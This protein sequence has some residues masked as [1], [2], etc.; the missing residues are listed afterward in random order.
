MNILTKGR[1]L[2]MCICLVGMW[3]WREMGQIFVYMSAFN[4]LQC[5]ITYVIKIT[6]RGTDN[7]LESIHRYIYIS[8]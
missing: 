5:I 6:S 7:Q 2:Y 8:K 4:L 3:D 1:I